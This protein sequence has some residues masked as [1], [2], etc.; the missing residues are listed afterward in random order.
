MSARG[1][2]GD[3]HLDGSFNREKEME[4]LE[5]A[6]SESTTSLKGATELVLALQRDLQVRKTVNLEQAD[7]IARL[8]AKL[9]MQSDQQSS[10]DAIIS[11]ITG[12]NFALRDQLKSRINGMDAL[13]AQCSVLSQELD[14][15]KS[16]QKHSDQAITMFKNKFDSAEA[17]RNAAFSTIRV[18]EGQVA[19]LTQELTD[20]K[21]Q[22]SAAGMSLE[23]NRQE[24]NQASAMIN[25]RDQMD[26][27]LRAIQDDLKRTKYELEQTQAELQRIQSF[28]AVQRD[29]I[30]GLQKGMSAKT[31]EVSLLST[32]LVKMSN[33]LEL[34]RES[35]DLNQDLLRT[36]EELLHTT[37]QLSLY[38]N[39]NQ[40][41]SMELIKT[42]SELERQRES[43]DLNQD[44]QR[45]KEE[46][47]HTTAQLSR[48]LNQNQALLT[49]ATGRAA[50]V[51]QPT[52]PRDV[53]GVPPTPPPDDPPTGASPQAAASPPE[54][55]GWGQARE[56]AAPPP[57]DEPAL[58]D[59]HPAGTAFASGIYSGYSTPR[60][61]SQLQGAGGYGG[62]QDGARRFSTGDDNRIL[63]A[64]HAWQSPRDPRLPGLGSRPP[65]VPSRHTP[66]PQQGTP[67]SVP[68]PATWRLVSDSPIIAGAAPGGFGLRQSRGSP[69]SSNGGGM[70]LELTAEEVRRAGL[71][72]DREISV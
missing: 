50:D 56:R 53:G 72:P 21:A 13:K 19:A 55:N 41:L 62:E 52:D 20:T 57:A 5:Q 64:G 45:T 65:S 25:E 24:L 43:A 6:L 30:Q 63:D 14:E 7:T 29:E 42:R 27:K 15:L 33:E 9:R 46:L 70:K 40:A 4:E 10:E 61:L 3:G 35:A 36:K 37:A 66:D 69:G 23:R 67:I 49:Y 51:H 22:L 34:R 26:L 28:S 12:E 44:L 1:D 47:L 16:H 48:Y 2:P 18:L 58:Y 39:Q 54:S 17:E 8:E 38:L 11:H 32:E 31:S 60:Q 71:N 59:S 68:A